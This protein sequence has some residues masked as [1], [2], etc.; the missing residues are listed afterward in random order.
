MN[1]IRYDSP[2]SM[3]DFGFDF[4][5]ERYKTK[6]MGRLTKK[7][8][9][10][11]FDINEITNGSIL[12]IKANFTDKLF[13]ILPQIQEKG[14]E[15]VL[16]TGR[17][18]SYINQRDINHFM[19]F[20]CIGSWYRCNPVQLDHRIKF[21]P[22]GFTEEEREYGSQSTIE[23]IYN[24]KI[25]LDDKLDMIYVPHFSKTN[26][27]RHSLIDSF[28]EKYKDRC[29]IEENRL[30]YSDYLEKLSK[31]KY[32]LVLCGAGQ[33]V[34]RNYECLLTSTIPIMEHSNVRDYYQDLNIP[35]E[36]YENFSGNVEFDSTHKDKLLYNYWYDMVKK[37]SD[38]LKKSEQANLEEEIK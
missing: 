27:R 24:R 6:G 14:I 23:N 16:I 34:H 8:K 32:C 33:D 1:F 15:I 9:E 30:K 22:I 36:L 11:H 12:Y 20:S 10:V 29:V 17:G 4:S 37:D 35:I 5:N 2:V 19:K 13:E 31:F 25:N 28:V 26:D 21:L 3:C 18:D 7:R 38:K